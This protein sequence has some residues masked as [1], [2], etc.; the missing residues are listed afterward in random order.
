MERIVVGVDGSDA[1]VAA[2]RWAVDEAALRNAEVDAVHAWSYPP[3]AMIPMPMSPPAFA[4][5]ELIAESNAILARACDAV[6]DHE[7]VVVRR[8]VVEGGASRCL[9]DAAK[10]ADLLVVGSR[11]RGGFAGLLLGSVSRQCAEHAPCPVVIVR[12][13]SGG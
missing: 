6:G 8:I 4:N 11:G 2:L 1:A 3:V 5:D 10:D 13:G 9:L 12:G 7:G